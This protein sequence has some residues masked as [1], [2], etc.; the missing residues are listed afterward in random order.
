MLYIPW[1]KYADI[2]GN[3]LTYEARYRE[4]KENIDIGRR[5]Y[6][7]DA[8]ANIYQLEKEVLS[9]EVEE[10][11]VPVTELQHQ[12]ECDAQEGSQQSHD[13]GCFNPGITPKK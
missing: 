7:D 10:P 6:V 5:S 3:Y 13:Y 12:N 1:R 11:D 9:N 4:N 8:T 2:L